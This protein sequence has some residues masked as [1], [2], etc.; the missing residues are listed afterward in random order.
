MRCARLFYFCLL[1]ASAPLL[2]QRSRVHGPVDNA[3][4]M[5]LSGHVH[6]ELNAADDLGRMD[7]TEKVASVTLELRQSPEQQAALE[8]LL[9]EQQD[10]SSPNY[11]RWITP[12]EYAARFGVS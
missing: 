9:A 3:N 1:I 12:D 7:L 10:P 11:R 2:A 8:K 6:A 5:R 4:R